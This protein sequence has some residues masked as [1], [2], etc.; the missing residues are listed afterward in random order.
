MAVNLAWAGWIW[1]A[2]VVVAAYAGVSGGGERPV[3]AAAAA[4]ALAPA[5]AGFI[6]LPWSGARLGALSLVLVWLVALVG[7]VAGTGGWASPLTVGL[8]I[9]IAF[10]RTLGRWTR[11]AGIG[12][13]LGYIAAGPFALMYA[14]LGRFSVVLTIWSLVLIVWL[15]GF[16]QRRE[17]R[18]DAAS[19]RIAEVSH[20]LR[21]PLTHILGFSEMIERQIFG[22]VGARYVEYAGLIRKSG[23]H[24]LGL[25][26]DLLDLS[27]IDA[28]RFDLQLGTF[29]A[30]VVIEDVVRVSVDSA[31]KKQIALGMLTPEAPLNVHADDRAVKRMLINTI[32]NA[33]KFTP[34]GGRVMV[35]ASEVNGVLQ[36]DTID[37]GPGIPE[38]ERAILG[39][40]Y[41]RGSG[42]ARAEGT[43]L[44]LSL[45]RALAALHGGALSFH[46]A[47]G[48]GA[49]VR[50]TLPVLAN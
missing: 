42:G 46:E 35:Q 31:E 40:A 24:L 1:V 2:G 50:I 37:N 27:R 20:E 41:E 8:L 14:G 18:G 13:V 36:L 10:A 11:I 3:V 30:R 4:L 47:P 45:V 25:V 19:Q 33:I 17:A 28:G 22:E 23:T 5:L 26:N 21:T 48:G 12:A 39:Q 7:L 43:G 32:S 9:P 34:E 49:L 38:A 16:A 15:M 6:I 44:G 29:D